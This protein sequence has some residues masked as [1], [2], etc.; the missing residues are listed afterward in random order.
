MNKQITKNSQRWVKVLLL[1]VSPLL[2]GALLLKPNDPPPPSTIQV[3][4]TPPAESKLQPIL[5]KGEKFSEEQLWRYKGYP[6]FKSKILGEI[7]Q[8]GGAFEPEG[9]GWKNHKTLALLADSDQ[10]KVLHAGHYNKGID[11]VVKNAQNGDPFA[12]PKAIRTSWPGTVY[13]VQQEPG[14]G[15]RCHIDFDITVRFQGQ[16]YPLYGAYAHAESFSVEP[17]QHIAQGE[18]IGIMGKTGGDYGEHVDF[19]TW[20]VV[21]GQI[22]GV[23]PN[24]VE[25]QL[26]P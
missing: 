3:P 4:P 6:T 14:Y 2:C 20:I 15:N 19:F 18:P 5:P 9:H 7:I 1:L 17:G 13:A 23:S 21:D 12:H 16:D 22:I 10:P 25:Q 24:V 26:H 11:Y 8:T